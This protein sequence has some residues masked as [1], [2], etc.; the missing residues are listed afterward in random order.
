MMAKSPVCPGS[1]ATS[2][3]KIRF[4]IISEL[5]ATSLYEQLAATTEDEK[6]KNNF[7]EIAADEK[8]HVGQLSTLLLEQDEEQVTMSKEGQAEADSF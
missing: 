1:N 3:E 8:K 7:L 6:L 5:D 2:A 4:A